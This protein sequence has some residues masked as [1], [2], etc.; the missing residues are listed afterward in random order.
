ML[1]KCLSLLLAALLGLTAV[2]AS[3]AD[4]PTIVASFYPIYAMAA[5][6]LEGVAG[7]ELVSLT[8]PTNGCL[9]DQAL[10]VTDVKTL[11]EADLL[12][13]NGVGMESYIEDVLAQLPQLPVVDASVGVTLIKEPDQDEHEED[14][15]HDHGEYNAHI[16]LSVPN[17]IQMVTNLAKGLCT[18]LPES[19]AQI[20]KNRDSYIL[21]LTTLDTELHAAL[22]PYQGRQIVTFHEAFTY[23]A[24]AY[25]LTVAATLVTEPEEQ[26]SAG[27]MARLCTLI[28][29][30]GLPPLFTEPAYA[31][32]AAELIANETGTSVYS[33]DPCTTGTLDRPQVLT[34]YED[35][36]RKN[37]DTLLFAFSK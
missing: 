8:P 4:H 17:A 27:E 26:L 21:R 29:N 1:R 10:M 22:A 25:G 35:A 12:L 16:W 5:N 37:M 32:P 23:F 30:A 13:I 7:A 33:L 34:A 19:Q 11:N 28:K 9:H 24:Q 14:D 36:L 15:E 6:L 3:A 20:E 18:A 2:S 31:C